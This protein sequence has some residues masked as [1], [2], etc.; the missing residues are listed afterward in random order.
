MQ[1]V[2]VAW[3]DKQATYLARGVAP[4]YGV[5]AQP[6]CRRRAASS[7]PKTCGL[8]RRVVFLGSEVARK[9][10][11]NTPPVGQTRADQGHSVR[12]H[13]RAEREG[14]ALELPQPRQGIVFI[15]YTTA[16]Q[17]WNTEYLSM[18]VYQAVIP[19]LDARTTAEVKKMLAARLRFNPADDRAVQ[20]FGSAETQQHHR[21][22]SCLG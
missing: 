21:A 16:G 18:I 11:G 14:A 1:D 6:A 8:Q 22:A 10:F 5:D 17:L 3:Q 15:P 9:M 20:V 13:R 19:T 4:A 2:P 7:T 12:R